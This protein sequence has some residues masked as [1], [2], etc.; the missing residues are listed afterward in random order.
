MARLLTSGFE[1]AEKGAASSNLVDIDG[2][3]ATS[4]DVSLQGTT[5]RSGALAL[6]RNSGT[7]VWRT[8]WGTGL[9]TADRNYYARVYFRIA[10]TASA[11]AIVMF[12]CN[13]VGA[14]LGPLVSGALS[15]AYA[16]WAGSQSLRY[17]LLTLAPGYFWA[18]WH[19]WRASKSVM[20]DLKAT[21]HLAQ[22][23]L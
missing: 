7:S 14:G 19:A 22:D 8:N 12:F 3:S 16:S 17:A 2:G 1:I 15:D 10:G 4:A 6:Q 21:H 9:G 13:L 11:T 18:A 20:Q 23:A 5:V